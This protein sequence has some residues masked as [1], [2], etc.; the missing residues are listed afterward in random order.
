MEFGRRWVGRHIVGGSCER[1]FRPQFK[2]GRGL[3]AFIASCRAEPD[4]NGRVLDH[5]VVR[6]LKANITRRKADMRVLFHCDV[7]A[8]LQLVEESVWAMST[9]SA[10]VGAC[11]SRD[12]R[13]TSTQCSKEATLR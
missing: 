5:A 10:E 12:V 8:F 11:G 1:A 7:E 4:L 6:P 9:L 13:T 3:A 2:R